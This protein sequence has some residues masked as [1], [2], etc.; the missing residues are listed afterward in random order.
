M[1]W[2]FET[3]MFNILFW[4]TANLLKKYFEAGEDL[5]KPQRQLLISLWLILS[6]DFYSFYYFYTFCYF[7]TDTLYVVTALEVPKKWGSKCQ[8]F[9]QDGLIGCTDSC[10]GHDASHFITKLFSGEP[11]VLFLTEISF[12]TSSLACCVSVHRVGGHSHHPGDC[13]W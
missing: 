5:L 6:L 3:C 12:S 10:N 4:E 13:G 1:L 8:S 7:L 9:N 2:G 11:D